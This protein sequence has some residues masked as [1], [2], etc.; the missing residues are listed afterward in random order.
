MSGDL[1]KDHEA[2]PFKLSEAR[3]KGQVAKSS[4]LPSFFSM[5]ASFTVLIATVGSSA[6]YLSSFL[7]WWLVNA[8]NLATSNHYLWN[9]LVS[10]L[11]GIS[12]ITLS[13]I[14]SGLVASILITLIHVGPVFS[15]F[16]LKP[17][18][19]RISPD[20]GFKKIFSRKSLVDVIL[21]GLKT[22]SFVGVTYIIWRYT[23]HKILINNHQTMIGVLTNWRDSFSILVFSLLGVFFIFS[24]FDLWYSKKE[25]GR[26]MRMSTR[27]IKDEN[28]RREGD[29]EIKAKRKKIL[30]EL[31]TRATSIKNT[32]N[33]DVIIT[34]PT[35]YSVALQ[36]KPGVMPAPIVVSKGKGFLAASI[37]RIARRHQVPIFRQPALTREIYRSVNIGEPIPTS[38]QKKV[39]EIYRWVISLP[40]SKVKLK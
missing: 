39:A 16:S 7:K 33:S 14:L 3:K 23:A 34:N 22:I 27:E 17:D 29:P 8:N 9:H 24:I 19:S 37:R 36:F 38:S 11:S 21:L 35:H 10:Y 18:F 5:I 31:L 20:K 30:R 15:T 13:I 26:Q 4:E 6:A 2:T 1:N 28:K 25:F 12:R 32:K 40:S